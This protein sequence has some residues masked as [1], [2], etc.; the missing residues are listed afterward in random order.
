MSHIELVGFGLLALVGL[1]LSG[2]FSGIETGIYT[3]N[4]RLAG[5]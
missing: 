5:R 3:L 2:L 4:P 1:V